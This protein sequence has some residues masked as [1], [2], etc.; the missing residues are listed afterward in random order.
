MLLLLAAACAPDAPGPKDS[1]TA[2]VAATWYRDDDGDGWG[3]DDTFLHTCAPPDGWVTAAG[4]CDDHDAARHPGAV[5]ACGG[6]DEDCDGTT[7]PDGASG[8]VDVWADADGDGLGAGDATCTCAPGDD[9]VTVDGDC[10]PDDADR[11]ADCGEAEQIARQ[12]ARIYVDGEPAWA[13]GAAELAADA[14]EELLFI[15]ADR[16]VAVAAPA[17]GD[18][19]LS[20]VTLGALPLDARD[21]A[22]GDVDG[23]GL[24]ELVTANLAVDWDDTD[25]TRESYW[26]TPTIGL[27]PGPLAAGPGSAWEVALDAVHTT[28]SWDSLLVADL[29]ADGAVEIWY[30]LGAGEWTGDAMAWRIDADGAATPALPSGDTAPSLSALHAAGDVD[31]D[32]F[33]DVAL[34]LR[35]GR[36]ASVGVHLGPVLALDPDAPD[37]VVTAPEDSLVALG[38]LDGDGLDE[39]GFEADDEDRSA[40]IVRG[41]PASGALPDVAAARIGAENDGVHESAVYLDAG[42][43]G[44][45]GTRE[46]VVTD[47][48]WP[49][50]D[51]DPARRG[52]LYVFA[53]LPSGV[54]D[55]RAADARVNGDVDEG[56]F[57]AVAVLEDGRLLARGYAEPA[58][59]DASPVTWLLEGL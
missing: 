47:W 30:T 11:G 49:G 29:D 59:T 34:V 27:V 38:D 58:T 45:D 57:G 26:A 43:L 20:T 6:A 53:S 10:D 44:A 3:W 51:T 33:T 52:A 14:G 41:P 24:V 54:V 13:Q 2:C 1:G 50:W 28:Y 32:G 5:E 36:D 55:V 35:V 31:G 22:L 7:D 17:A 16:L 25:P 4:D 19:T 9:V 12:G 56:Y 39:L 23:D 18:T 42:D 21:A 46:L 15:D 37:A 8:C 40:W 48:W